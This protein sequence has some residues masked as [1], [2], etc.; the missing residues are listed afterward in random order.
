MGQHDTHGSSCSITAL[1]C[2]EQGS[3]DAKETVEA[4]KYQLAMI[5]TASLA[6]QAQS[7][8]NKGSYFLFFSS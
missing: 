8:Y 3:S 2:L 4:S 5:H 6:Q 7:Y 1:V